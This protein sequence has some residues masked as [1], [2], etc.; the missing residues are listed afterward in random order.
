MPHRSAPELYCPAR[1]AV[2]AHIAQAISIASTQTTPF[3]PGTKVASAR[4]SRPEN[5]ARDRTARY[6]EPLISIVVALSM[7]GIER[8]KSAE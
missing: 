2:L 6:R 3:T 1:L 5:V 8:F 4:A 7:T